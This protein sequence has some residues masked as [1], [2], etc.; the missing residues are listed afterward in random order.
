MRPTPLQILARLHGIQ[1]GYRNSFGSWNHA[2]G[3]ALIPALRAL[4][5]PVD[6][7]MQAGDL[8]RSRLLARWRRVLE[9][10]HVLWDDHPAGIVVRWPDSSAHEAYEGSIEL[11]AGGELRFSGR[12]GETAPIR[13]REIEGDVFAARRLPL[14]E[15]LPWGY[16]RLRLRWGAAEAHARLIRAPLRAAELPEVGPARTGFFAPLYSLRSK[17]NWGAGDYSDLRDFLRWSGDRAV[18]LVG[19]LPLLPTFLERA[20][21]PSPYSP[22]SRLFWSEFFIDPAQAPELEL[23]PHA[24]ERMGS[25]SFRREVEELCARP[26]VDYARVWA[27]KR[28][29]LRALAAALR[30]HPDRW[31]SRVESFALRTPDA[32]SYARF[33]ALHDRLG[34]RPW[35]EWPV[36]WCD[37]RIEAEDCDPS[38]VDLFL[39][40]QMLAHEQLADA[41]IGPTPGARSL[42][43]DLP[44]GANPDGFDLWKHRNAFAPKISVGAPPDPI[45][46]GG[47]DW[48]FAPF[49]PEQIREDGYDYF[50][51]ALRHH[52]S[53]ASVLRVDHV[54]CFHRLF[55]I[56]TGLSPR[57]GVYVHYRAEEFYAIL[58]LES[59]RHGAA[60]VGED[61]GTV[62]GPVREAMQRHGIRRTYAMQLELRPYPDHA[63]GDIPEGSVA[64]V[65]THD[66]SPFLAFWSGADIEERFR[67]GLLDEEHRRQEEE[68]RIW[69]QRCLIE[70][71]RR[72]GNLTGED[73]SPEAVLQACLRALRASRAGLSLVNLEDFWGERERQNLPG[74]TDEHPNWTRKM[75]YSLEELDAIE[76]VRRFLEEIALLRPS[77]GG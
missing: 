76:G 9:P 7:E 69:L 4:G 52:L 54:M 62:P 50:I 33:R 53:R 42:Y 77:P 26:H 3:E 43:L 64:C 66:L 10:V 13:S 63:L 22:V 11:E 6:H 12:I 23:C 61:L 72:Q 71:L 29:L 41:A 28:P 24:R 20:F 59:R 48:G 27:L 58:T 70:H 73:E 30:R 25:E 47:Q 15:G 16:H 56:P 67:F 18:P 36:P 40:A 44:L 57:H 5:A 34:E 1:S 8:A 45:F 75:R 2:E 38:S 51:A 31:A 14:P 49:H 68:G 60:V 46:T 19:T 37:G 32:L 55:W 65:N 21:N 17:R 74:T 39:Y 35:W